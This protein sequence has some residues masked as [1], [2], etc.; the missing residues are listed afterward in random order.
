MNTHASVIDGIQ[1]HEHRLSSL[2]T[3][4][5]TITQHPQTGTAV[6]SHRGVGTGKTLA[7]EHENNIWDTFHGIAEIDA[8]PWRKRIRRYYA[9][10]LPLHRFEHVHLNHVQPVACSQLFTLARTIMQ[11]S[12]YQ[13]CT[14]FP[15]VVYTLVVLKNNN[16]GSS[17]C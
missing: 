10:R 7:F 12:M 6:V 13:T 14:A 11:V 2:Q 8:A 5:G 4:F 3:P 1:Y 16:A 9:R 15:H 17:G